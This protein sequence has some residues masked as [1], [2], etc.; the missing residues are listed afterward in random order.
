MV[1]LTVKISDQTHHVGVAVEGVLIKQSILDPVSGE[2]CESTSNH[3]T[4]RK[5]TREHLDYICTHTIQN[6]T[7]SFGAGFFH[8][9]VFKGVRNTD[10]H[11]FWEVL[12]SSFGSL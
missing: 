7:H 2:N 11:S 9:R 6:Y 3:T 12:Y 8:K 10:I 4:V 5:I 1:T